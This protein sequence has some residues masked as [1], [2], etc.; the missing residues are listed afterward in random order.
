KVVLTDL[1]IREVIIIDGD[2][3]GQTKVEQIRHIM[4]G[5]VEIYRRNKGDNGESQWKIHDEWVTSRDDIPLV[6]LYTKR[7]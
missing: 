2:D 6:T 4:P 7:T 1:R 3:Y 5:K